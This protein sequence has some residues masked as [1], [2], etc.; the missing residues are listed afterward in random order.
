MNQHKPP[1]RIG[2]GPNQGPPPHYE[3]SDDAGRN[4][5]GKPNSQAKNRSTSG[6]SLFY[7]PLTG[8][9]RLGYIRFELERKLAACV[10]LGGT[11]GYPIQPHRIKTAA[12]RSLVNAGMQFWNWSC[13]D[14]TECTGRLESAAVSVLMATL[15]RPIWGQADYLLME[16]LERMEQL[17]AGAW[18]SGRA[19]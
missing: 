11:G 8:P 4:D 18:N 3:P 5:L 12:F 10:A 19:L 15:D 16:A 17:Q 13:K 9:K 6:G 7:D 14:L 2:S 1:K